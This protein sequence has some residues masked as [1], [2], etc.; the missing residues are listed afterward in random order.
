MF[1]KTCQNMCY[2]G[3]YEKVIVNSLNFGVYI[4]QKKKK[5]AGKSFFQNIYLQ[6]LGCVSPD[7]SSRAAPFHEPVFHVVLRLNGA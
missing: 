5:L 3:R 2:K 1:W 6:G 7:G 4:Q